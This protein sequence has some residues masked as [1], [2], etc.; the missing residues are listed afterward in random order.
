MRTETP[1]GPSQSEKQIAPGLCW[2]STAGHGGISLSAER[3][4]DFKRALPKFNGYAPDGWLEEDCDWAAAA[5]VWPDDFQ[6][7]AVRA[8]VETVAGCFGNKSYGGSYNQ[9]LVDYLASDAGARAR[10]IAADYNA[11]IN[12]LWERGSMFGGAG[13]RGWQVCFTQVGT[14]ER[15]GVNFREYPLKNLYTK[16]ELDAEAL[17]HTAEERDIVTV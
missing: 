3:W 14:N 11:K 10:K 4:Q 13:I 6:P 9:C 5:I 1:W 12:G 7:D 2:F 15:R 17:A 16:A 8:A